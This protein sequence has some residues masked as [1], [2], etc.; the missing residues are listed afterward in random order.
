MVSDVTTQVELSE[1]EGRVHV[2]T[3][4]MT[5]PLTSPVLEAAAGSCV[6][7]KKHFINAADLRDHISRVHVTDRLE[8]Q[9]K[10]S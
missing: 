1:G 8:K 5:S 4:D 10:V 7:C 2:K 6:F 3:E 9:F